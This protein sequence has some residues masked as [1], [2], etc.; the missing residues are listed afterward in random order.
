[1]VQ[2]VTQTVFVGG[3]AIFECNYDNISWTY[4]GKKNDD[5]SIM[6]HGTSIERRNVQK[7]H[8][9]YYYCLK[10]SADDS[11]I[12]GRGLLYVIGR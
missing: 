2:P 4:N 6:L 7:H 10:K 12:Y 3:S 5:D 8:G 9:G 1:M 11:V